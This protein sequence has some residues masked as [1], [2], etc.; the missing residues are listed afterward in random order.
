[1]RPLQADLTALIQEL[2]D[3]HYDTIEIALD[4][5]SNMADWEPHLAYLRELSRAARGVL[6]AAGDSA[7]STGWD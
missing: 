6:A 4:T 7:S 1:M 3:A 5:G 2:V